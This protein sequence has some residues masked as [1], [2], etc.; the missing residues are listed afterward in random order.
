MKFPYKV[1]LENQKITLGSFVN[2]VQFLR[3]R[4]VYRCVTLPYKRKFFVTV[5]GGGLKISFFVGRHL[6]TTLLGLYISLNNLF[7]T[8]LY[9]KMFLST[10]CEDLRHLSIYFFTMASRIPST[11]SYDAILFDEHVNLPSAES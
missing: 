2:D 10:K 11:G 9:S 7:T 4:G 3:E 6:R 5:G 1:S 8:S